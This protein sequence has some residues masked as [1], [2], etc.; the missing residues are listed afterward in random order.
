MTSVKKMDCPILQKG[1]KITKNTVPLETKVGDQKM[2][3]GEKLKLKLYV[4]M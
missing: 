1:V 2:E 3:A 4:I